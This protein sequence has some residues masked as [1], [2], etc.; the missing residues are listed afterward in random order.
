MNFYKKNRNVIFISIL[1][2]LSFAIHLCYLPSIPLQGDEAVYAEIIDEFMHNPAPIPHF[3]GHVIS[4]KPPLGFAVY[5]AI[6]YSFHALN[7]SI[8]LEVY[9]RLPSLIFG[10]LSTLALYFLV[11][12]LYGE[13]AAFFS[14]FIFTA[15]VISIAIGDVLMLE[16]LVLFL[17]I[18]GVALYMEGE[19][20]KKY[21]YY[22]GFVG[23]LLF[24]TKSIIAFL[25]PALAIAYYFGNKKLGENQEWGRA[26]LISLAAVPLAMS[27]YAML[28]FMNAPIGKGGDITISYIYD[29]FF[30]VYGKSEQPMLLLNTI[31]FLKLTLPWSI[32]L[33][34]GF[35]TLK[36]SR[37]EDRFVF[38]WAVLML[39]FLGASQF[40][41][42]YYL[43][44]LP[45]FSIL[46]A[47]PLLQI[48]NSKFFTPIF[49]LLFLLSF[50]Y[51]ANPA[52]MNYHFVPEQSLLERVEIG[53]FLKGKTDI[54]SITEQGIPETVFYKFH[55]ESPPDY[56]GFEMK[57]LDP[58][59]PGSYIAFTTSE[60]ALE[61]APTQNLT[62]S[63]QVKNLFTNVSNNAYVVM[64]SNV[65]N[66]YSSSPLEN[67]II[68]FNSSQGS[69]IVLKKVT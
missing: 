48:K 60:I 63:Q 35:L 43:I 47:K 11:R 69:Y 25:L 41:D 45:P 39:V 53:F 67:Y 8:P 5:S 46:C 52:F 12:K 40:Y 62:D 28:F 23:A 64:D 27:L 22:A 56:S 15:N 3:M 42:W 54:I 4:W 30:R 1:F 55:G 17:L 51:I 65:Y 31:E 61:V 29:L 33:F 59:S 49:L 58:T 24:L 37:R 6:I 14:S 32:L 20:N 10:V 18:L 38:L 21:F 66:T 7:S 16:T 2:L 36:L 34:A 13:E 44:V 9:Y 50:P 57:V 26:F 19:R 68:D